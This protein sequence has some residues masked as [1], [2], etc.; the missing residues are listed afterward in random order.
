AAPPE[1]PVAARVGTELV[2]REEERKAGLRHLDAPELDAAGR[3]A[4]ARGRPPVAGGGG[5][6][7]TPR[8]EQ[9]PDERAPGARVDPLERDAEA[10]GPA[11]HDAVRARARERLEHGLGDVL[12]AVVQIGRASCRE[13]SVDLGGRRIIKKKRKQEV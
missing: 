4:L 1:S 11:R 7:A 12:G 9:V 8:V 3:L 10:L 6:P 2:A 5:A 13:K